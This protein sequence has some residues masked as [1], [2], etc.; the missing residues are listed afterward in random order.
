MRK[1]TAALMSAVVA[2]MVSTLP[3]FASPKGH[4]TDAGPTTLVV[5]QGTVRDVQGNWLTIQTRDWKP[6]SNALGPNYV[7]PGSQFRVNVT[8]A[9]EETFSGTVVKPS[10]GI[11]EAIVAV[12]RAPHAGNQESDA[13]AVPALT[14]IIIEEVSGSGSLN[15]A[16]APAAAIRE[17]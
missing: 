11:G 4:S 5:I 12:C 3:V 13:T 2:I 6:F 10:L 14:A 15:G 1:K 17:G 7:V 9:V 16:G 8:H